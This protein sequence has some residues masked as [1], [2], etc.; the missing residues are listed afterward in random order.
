MFN[1][2][3]VFGA[4]LS[5]GSVASKSHQRNFRISSRFSFGCLLVPE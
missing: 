2:E 5:A 3:S 4:A 1:E